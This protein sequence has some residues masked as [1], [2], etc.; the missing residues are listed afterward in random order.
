MAQMISKGA[1]VDKVFY[2]NLALI[3]LLLRRTDRCVSSIIVGEPVD[4]GM[5]SI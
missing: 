1:C 3:T 5:L 2:F 4:R